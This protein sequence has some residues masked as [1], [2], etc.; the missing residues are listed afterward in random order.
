[1]KV[2][3]ETIRVCLR[4]NPNPV[5]SEGGLGE[6]V[7]TLLAQRGLIQEELAEKAA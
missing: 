7:A 5:R 4:V 2:V 6:N 1:M 3:I